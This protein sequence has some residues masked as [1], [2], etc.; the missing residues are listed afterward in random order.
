MGIL[1]GIDESTWN[2]ATDCHLPEP[3]DADSL[4]GKRPCKAHVQRELGLE[5]GTRPLIAFVSRLTRQKM[6]DVVAGSID[7]I[8]SQGAQLALVGNGDKSIEAELVAVARKY[9]GQVAVH[10]GYEE[11]LAHRLFA[12]AD[13]ILAPARFEPC[14]LTP[15][16]AM[17]YGSLPL[18]RRTGGM[19]DAVT[20]A[21]RQTCARDA[22]TGFAFKNATGEDMLEG[23]ADALAVY[24]DRARWRR[25]Q[26]RAMRRECGW[27][28]AARQYLALY[29]QMSATRSRSR[30]LA[31]PR[32][33]EAVRQISRAPVS[34]EAGVAGT[35]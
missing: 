9:P 11:S 10:I 4:D 5:P 15:I 8:A 25:M 33:R 26:V 35:P 32:A 19:A 14:G 30:P 6:A 2:P 7:R 27:T 22:A 17:R 20:P 31:P 23:I 18:V 1:N 3:Y 13:I 28:A 29:D 24:K 21:N 34:N 12:G 16:Y